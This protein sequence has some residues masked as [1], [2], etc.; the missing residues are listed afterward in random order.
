MDDNGDGSLRQA[1]LDAN[2][3]AGVANI[4]FT[5]GLGGTLTLASPLP[6]LA[7]V[8]SITGGT[9]LNGQPLIT[10]LRPS[11]GFAPN[12]ALP[13]GF[14]LSGVFLGFGYTPQGS[15]IRN[16]KITGFPGAGVCIGSDNNVIQGCIITGNTGDGICIIDGS[17]NLIGGTLPGQSNSIYRNLGNGVVIKKSDAATT[18][19][20]GNGV[21]ANSIFEN[22][23]TRHRPRRRGRF[24]EPVP[25]AP[26]RQQR[27]S[28]P[29]EGQLRSVLS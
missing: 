25:D 20:S 17:N 18:F 22:W 2:A 6:A 26:S 10:V 21:L 4:V 23:Q 29:D 28:G 12:P 16:L 13:D 7:D 8:V 11:S 5:S 9:G 24:D 27:S 14:Q 1:I 3:A 15:T 19:P